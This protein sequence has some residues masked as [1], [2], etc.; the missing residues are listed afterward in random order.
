MP[1]PWAGNTSDR[2]LRAWLDGP[3]SANAAELA[4]SMPVPGSVALRGRFMF[5]TD[6]E[7]PTL[8]PALFDMDR[9][10]W[11]E[12]IR[13]TSLAD[14]ALVDNR[15]ED[16]RAALEALRESADP[17]RHQLPV[18]DA[19]I[20]LADAAR[21]SDDPDEA[22][23][24]L[25][26]ALNIARAQHY[27]FGT[28][29]ALVTLGYLAM[30]YRSL[31]ESLECFEAAAEVCRSLDE[32]VYLANAL[33]GLG[34]THSRLRVDDRAEA[35]LKE[36]IDIF[37]SV[38]AHGGVVNAAQHLG[39]LLRRRRE[40][41]AARTAF[42]QALST[43][44]RH[45]P[46][47][48]VV[49]ALDGLAEVTVGLDQVGE[50]KQHY[51]AAYDMSVTRHYIRGEAHALN[52]L[53]R[54]AF[55]E[56]DWT[57]AAQCH[58]AALAR[59]RALEDLPSAT[60]AL[61]GLARVAR[62]AG[63]AAS[64]VE[65]R[66]AAVAAIEE[67]RSAQDRH[68]YQQEYRRRFEAVYS[69][70]MR[71]ALEASDVAAF[72]TVFEG[73]AGRRLAGVITSLADNNFGAASSTI[74]ATSGGADPSARS[75]VDRL[76]GVLDYALHGAHQEDARRSMDDLAAQLYRPF[77]ADSAVPLINRL[78]SRTDALLVCE[79]PGGGGEVA[80]LRVRRRNEA[81]E[82]GVVSPSTEQF[83]LIRTLAEVGLAPEVRPGDLA[84]LN[85]LLPP[86]AYRNDDAD[87]GRLL[88]V[89]L[90]LLWAVPW[91][92]I[93]TSDGR[94]LGE[95]FA[96]AIAPSVT[97][98]DHLS[99]TRSELPRSV[100]TWRNPHL[101][102]HHIDAFADDDRVT[103]EEMTNATAA[104]DALVTA[105][106][107][108]VVVAGHGKPIGRVGLYLELD[109]D[110]FLEPIALL[111]AHP[112]SHLVLVACWG[113][114][115]PGTPASDPMTIATLALARGA[116]Q[117]MATTSELADDATASRFVN[118]VLHRLP[119]QSAAFALRDETRRFLSVARNRSGPL[120]RWA[121]LITAGTT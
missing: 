65:H 108:L 87:Q 1:D 71:A 92:A 56:R 111:N 107:D 52:G 13:L 20:G 81:I 14:Q 114:R 64:M 76:A 2:L 61:D 78:C 15:I 4:R 95:R 75:R 35:E 89:P 27:R 98:A 119:S 72:V 94:H 45:G 7:V 5:L 18:V 49:N 51:Q 83:A 34:E 24:A 106:H 101:I 9:A 62:A 121:P 86:E 16:A 116:V 77:S 113:A 68:D 79:M 22:T 42:R 28:A 48:G 8:N 29:R 44:Q 6:D 118:N 50:A 19:L 63:D 67:M 80:W 33:T 91:P 104:I 84:P 93:A 109:H 30:Q 32:R 100:G 85:D 17:A 31:A 11:D 74:D 70:A 26:T 53:G 25:K 88:I 90:G 82:I 36:A 37:T 12:Q 112:P 46:W 117:V 58:V 120:A 47:I 73:I 66:L 41:D 102:N 115:R 43:A 39:D 103:V 105:R 10:T 59:Y 57:T 40:F 60:T 99:S 54:C 38:Q 23:D 97:L 69:W 3:N 21:Q 110:A 55:I 96:L